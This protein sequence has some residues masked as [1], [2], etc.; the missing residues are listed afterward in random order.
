MRLL[1]I[2]STTIVQVCL[3]S[4]DLQGQ[5]NRSYDGSRNNVIHE[6]WGAVNSP[7]L[8]YV[9]NGYAD[10]IS[11]PG[12]ID[13]A[14]SR[15]ISNKL[16]NQIG[17]INDKA[18]MSAFSWAFG[19]FIDHD[20][21]LTGNNPDEVME[22]AIPRG[23]LHFDPAGTGDQVMRIH[24]SIAIE[25]S[26]TGPDSPRQYPNQ[27]STWIDASNVY[28]SSKGRADWLRTFKGG[29]LKMSEG[30]LLPFNTINGA[31]DSDIDPQAPSMANDGNPFPKYFVAGDVR[32]GENPCLL[33]LHTLFLREHNRLC[34]RLAVDHPSWS[35][36]SLYQYA[37][38][39]VG[40]LLQHIVYNE[41]LPSMGVI[42]PQYNG[43]IYNVNP[44]IMNVFTAAAY[45]WGHTSANSVILRLNDQGKEIPQGHL[46]LRN[47]YFNPV[48]I[49]TG[50]GIAPLL[51][52]MAVKQQ[53]SLDIKMVDDMRNF[54]FGNPGQGG[55]DLAAINIARGR[56]RGLPDYNTVRV[57]FGLEPLASFFDVS[58]DL[59]LRL[60]LQELYGDVNNIDAYVGLLIEPHMNEEAQFGPTLMRIMEIQFQ[61]LRDGD[62]YFYLNDLAISPDDREWIRQN[63]LSNIIKRNTWIT[64]LQENVFMADDGIVSSVGSIAFNQFNIRAFPNPTV[65]SF[66]LVVHSEIT[67]RATIKIID[68]L[69]K[70]LWTTVMMIS[71]GQNRIPI[72]LD[73]RLPDGIF[74]LVVRMGQDIMSI[75]MIKTSR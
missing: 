26:G 54:L 5:V 74:H 6:D 63:H 37:R 32:A 16:F 35:D 67:H 21:T 3:W 47:A 30:Q 68:D 75:Q 45:R 50:S 60:K 57:N 71:K 9:D 70:T 40:A 52:G 49:I 34:T 69:G 19:Q 31:F 29:K 42:L 1:F 11:E 44:G 51:K 55:L 73:D 33:A 43:Y 41:W 8:R 56:E 13:R 61:S 18:G 62:R 20:I 23:D 17:Q 28:G 15:E 72:H 10:G 2:L 25:G 53:Q 14:S 46:L 38:K 66:E 39:L 7:L 36:E 12:G 58:D 64:N 48:T 4:F 22:L 24:R 65:G 27:I 59:E